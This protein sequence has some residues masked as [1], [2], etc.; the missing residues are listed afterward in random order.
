MKPVIRWVF[1]AAN[2]LVAGSG[3]V[4]AVM[5]YLMEPTDRWSVVNHPWQPFVQHAHVLAAPLMVFV[6]GVLWAVH[7]TEKWQAG[8]PEGRK[9][10]IVLAVMT[11]PMIASGYLLQVAVEPLWRTLWEVSHLVTSALWLAV[12]AVHVVG[13]SKELGVKGKG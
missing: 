3:V 13:K 10:G 9:A 6:I 5:I 4:L 12:V 2:V 11:L 8:G 7:V 1:H